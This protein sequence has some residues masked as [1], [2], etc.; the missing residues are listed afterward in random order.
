MH[1]SDDYGLA[2]CENEKWLGIKES[3]QFKFCF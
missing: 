1:T 3:I 2:E